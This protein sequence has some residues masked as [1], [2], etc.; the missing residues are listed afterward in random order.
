VKPSSLA[1]WRTII[2]KERS[3]GLAY[4]L[5]AADGGSRPPSTYI[6]TGAGDVSAV[7][8]SLLPLNVWTHVAATY[9]GAELRLYV[10]GALA[11]TRVTS[12][13][14][15]ISAEPLRIGGNSVWGEF[16]AGAIDEVRVYKR[17]LTQAE[18]QSD[19]NVPVQ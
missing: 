15:L 4:A 7:A 1:D 8:S 2:L 12:G 11:A 18:I 6:N 3:P 17:A 10:N 9:N 19:M 16:F 14:V 13:G 5:Y